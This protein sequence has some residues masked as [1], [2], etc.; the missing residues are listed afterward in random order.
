MTWR[1]EVNRGHDA[2]W[3]VEWKNGTMSADPPEILDLIDL[4]V[5]SQ[6]SVAPTPTGPFVRPD[7]SVSHVAYRLTRMALTRA[8]NTPDSDVTSTGTDW[9]W[10]VPPSLPDRIY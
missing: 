3:W 6:S 8:F 4:L 9:I 7:L 5:E 1:I 10:P 2:P